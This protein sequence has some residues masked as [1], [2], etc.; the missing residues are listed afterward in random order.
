MIL[1]RLLDD[2]FHVNS[3]ASYILD[4]VKALYRRAK[5]YVGAWDP[6]LAKADFEAAVKADPSL[7]KTVAKEMKSLNDKIK[8]KERQDRTKL[9][10]KLFS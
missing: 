1:Q 3:Y 5:A 2:K 6:D 10:G 8:E 9:Q 7:E 4:N